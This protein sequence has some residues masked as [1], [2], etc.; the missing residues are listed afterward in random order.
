MMI[1]G[2][3]VTREQRKC[4]QHSQ[5][6]PASWLGS[7]VSR[8]HLLFSAAVRPG[9][10]RTAGRCRATSGVAMTQHKEY[11]VFGAERRSRRR[12]R[13]LRRGQRRNIKAERTNRRTGPDGARSQ[14]QTLTKT[15]RHHSVTF[16]GRGGW[17][18]D[19]EDKDSEDQEDQDSEDQDSE[20]Q[21]EQDSEDQDSED[22]D[23]EDQDS[24]DQDSE[25][26]DFGREQQEGSVEEA[27]MLEEV[28]MRAP[29]RRQA[30]LTAVLDVGSRDEDISHCEPGSSS[31][32]SS[33]SAET[34]LA[35]G[36]PGR[37]A[38]CEE[39]LLYFRMMCIRT[40]LQS[41]L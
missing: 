18:Q 36:T 8:A 14:K 37:Q 25:D 13:P 29:G 9:E 21:E 34:L 40:R 17:D 38:A 19:S 39:Q 35:A 27:W 7:P 24:E 6:R 16:R 3:C 2:L 11:F 12:T 33:S 15:D 32:E 30:E 5:Q 4:L 22:Q 28:S 41:S 23:S 26:Q 20:D 31:I 1:H 10:L